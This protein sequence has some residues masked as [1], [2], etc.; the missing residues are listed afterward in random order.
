[1]NEVPQCEQ[2]TKLMCGRKGSSTI[3]F[4]DNH[5]VRGGEAEKS[6]NGA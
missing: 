5:W 6:G 4:R 1:M 2:R 3:R